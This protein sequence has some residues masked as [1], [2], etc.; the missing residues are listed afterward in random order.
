MAAGARKPGQVNKPL[1]PRAIVQVVMP[2]DETASARQAA[3]RALQLRIIAF[4]R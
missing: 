4:V 2:V 3:E 1:F